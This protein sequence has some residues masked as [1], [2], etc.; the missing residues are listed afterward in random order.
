ML[1]GILGCL[2]KLKKKKKK[3]RAL[4][5]GVTGCPLSLWLCYSLAGSGFIHEQ[6]VS[7]W[8]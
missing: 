6:A 1:E 7:E 4:G 5:S 2:A 3:I 8:Y